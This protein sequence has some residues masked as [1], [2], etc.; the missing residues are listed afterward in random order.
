MTVSKQIDSDASHATNNGESQRR[1]WPGLSAL[2]LSDVWTVVAAAKMT[3]KAAQWTAATRA[4]SAPS[5]VVKFEPKLIT[6]AIKAIAVVAITSAKKTHSARRLS[7]ATAAATN[8]IAVAER[9]WAHAT[10]VVPGSILM[11]PASGTPSADA[12]LFQIECANAK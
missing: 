1:V 10:S 8:V 3:P 7:I 5:T 6:R 2:P 9:Y 4:G 12:V 11:L